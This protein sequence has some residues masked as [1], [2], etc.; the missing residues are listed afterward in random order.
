MDETINE[1]TTKEQS[2]PVDG[3]GQMV[4]VLSASA[5]LS[6]SSSSMMGKARQTDSV[7]RKPPTQTV[8]WKIEAIE[9]LMPRRGPICFNSNAAW[10]SYLIQAAGSTRYLHQDGPLVWSAGEGS[11]V[12]INPDFSYCRDCRRQHE[13]SMRRVGRCDPLFIERL[14]KGGT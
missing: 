2:A 10:Q 3:W 13:T 1:P 6:S 7:Y 5:A 11:T 9:R 14:T 4:D 12:Q 8:V